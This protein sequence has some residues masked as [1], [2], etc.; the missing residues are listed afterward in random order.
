MDAQGAVGRTPISVAHPLATRIVARLL[1]VEG[2]TQ[3]A[4]VDGTR[5]EVPGHG[6][7][8]HV[9]APVLVADRHVVVAEYGARVRAEIIGFGTTSDGFDMVM[10]EPSGAHSARCMR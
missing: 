1:E 2:V 6:D 3:A 5:Q 9:H 7:V 4:V 8:G 10:P